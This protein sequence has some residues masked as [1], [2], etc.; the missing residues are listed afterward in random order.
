MYI[1]NLVC[2]LVVPYSI[3]VLLNKL[4]NLADFLSSKKWTE[5]MDGKVR[6]MNEL[7]Y[8]SNLP[9]GDCG[10]L[11]KQCL[12]RKLSHSATRSH[13]VC[14][15]NICFLERRHDLPRIDFF[16]SHG[17]HNLL[18]TLPYLFWCLPY[19]QLQL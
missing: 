9:F 1:T 12:K 17:S 2:K 19:H 13:S 6:A 14:V 16:E 3:F 7:T 10:T 11:T 15:C 5:G 8:F 18:A 4:G